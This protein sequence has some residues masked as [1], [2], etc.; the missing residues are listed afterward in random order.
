MEQRLTEKLNELTTTLDKFLKRVTDLEEEFTFIEED[1]RRVKAV[2]RQK[3]ASHC[4]RGEMP[5]SLSHLGTALTCGLF[6][7]R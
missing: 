2:L 4:T 3:L 1:L 6:F 5:V 7:R